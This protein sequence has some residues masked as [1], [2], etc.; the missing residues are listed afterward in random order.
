MTDIGEIEIF[1][2]R[3]KG[4]AGIDAFIF[5]LESAHKPADIVGIDQIGYHKKWFVFFIGRQPLYGMVG[6][7]SVGKGIHIDR[8]GITDGRNGCLA[9]FF[10]P[11][12]SQTA[13][14]VPFAE[15][16]GF[17]S[18]LRKGAAQSRDGRIQVLY[19]KVSSIGQNS[20]FVGIDS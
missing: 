13:G 11:E 9:L 10:T 16:Y 6:G 4:D 3:R 15:M 8:P 20:C 12:T 5:P 7:I 1:R 14:V 2:Q 18:C 17:V 19:R